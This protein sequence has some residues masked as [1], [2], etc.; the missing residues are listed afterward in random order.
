MFYDN[1]HYF[2][3]EYEAWEKV[4]TSASGAINEFDN[5]N[6]VQFLVGGN[7]ATFRSSKDRN[8]N[9]PFDILWDDTGLY[10]VGDVQRN[11]Y[12][13]TLTLDY[14]L[15][16]NEFFELYVINDKSI[17]LYHPASGRIYKFVGKGYIQ[18][19]RSSNLNGKIITFDNPLKKRIQKTPRLSN[20]RD[21]K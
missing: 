8:R 12:L 19:Y 5:E 21:N 9:N 6:Y 15:S 2:L 10:G 3:Q 20:P 7:N 14:D 1:I 13:K 11:L 4:Y 17:E 18:Y 16:G